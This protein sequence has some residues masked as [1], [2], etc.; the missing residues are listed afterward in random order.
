[1]SLMF[2]SLSGIPVVRATLTLPFV[3][4]WHA[5]VYLDRALGPKLVGPQVLTLAGSTW[6]CAPVRA[7]DFSG[8]RGVRLVG[9]TGGW[10]TKVLYQEYQSPA[11]VPTAVVLGSVAGQVHEI[12]PVLGPTI[13]TSLGSYFCVQADYASL[14][15]SQVLGKSWWLDATGTVQS[16]P[17]PPTP[18][19]TPYTVVALDAPMGRYEVATEYPLQWLPGATFVAP[20]ATGTVSRVVH[21]LERGSLRTE[22][23]AWP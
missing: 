16:I 5:D 11:G 17:R 20:T 8:E 2:A 10:R 22:I 9:G 6:A 1:M 14:V 12:P 15:L 13:P 21:L 4:L 3:G 19:A 18:V 7:I 23:L